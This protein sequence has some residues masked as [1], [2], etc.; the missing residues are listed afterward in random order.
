MRIADWK[1][2][3]KPLRLPLFFNFAPL[4]GKAFHAKAQQKKN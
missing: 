2:G 1:E 3:L 4:R